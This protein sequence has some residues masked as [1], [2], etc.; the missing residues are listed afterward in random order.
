MKNLPNWYRKRH[1]QRNLLGVNEQPKLNFPDTN[2]EFKIFTD[3]FNTGVGAVLTQDKNIIGYFSHKLTNSQRKY[4]TIEKE[5]QGIILSLKNFRKI[6]LG[7]Q[8]TIVTDNKNDKHKTNFDN[9][10]GSWMALINEYAAQIVHVENKNNKGA[11]F[12]SRLDMVKD[13]ST[14]INPIAKIILELKSEF[15]LKNVIKLYETIG[16]P[17]INTLYNTIR[18][19]LP[20]N[21]KTFK[22]IKIAISGCID[23]KRNKS[24]KYIYGDYNGQIITQEPLKHIS[25]D[26]YGPFNL[27]D[28]NSERK[29]KKVYMITFT[30]RSSRYNKIYLTDSIESNEI[31]K[32]FK[33]S[34]LEFFQ[35]P[36]TLL[37][38]QGKGYIG[39][40]FRKFCDESKI[41]LQFSSIYYPTGNSSSE[42][43]N[44]HI[45]TFLRIYKKESINKIIQIIENRNNLMFHRSL[46][47]LQ[48]TYWE[49][50]TL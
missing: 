35:I 27:D 5:L 26:I 41:K 25:S 23:C 40:N 3:A 7:C 14:E 33:A 46:I 28:Y 29:V 43:F 12:L 49:L 39:K 37:T 30:D 22:I 6:I 24:N 42:I 32:A 10:T 19:Y 36:T 31:I 50:I 47:A 4:N 13:R 18:K 9:K 15:S 2:K 11:D 16:H 48:R 1:S 8:I 20:E 45:N 44:M 17:G 21:K 34:W 38:D